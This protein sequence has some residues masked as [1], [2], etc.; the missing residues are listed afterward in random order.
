ME[1]MHLAEKEQFCE[2]IYVEYILPAVEQ[3][4]NYSKLKV[5]KL[6][7]PISCYTNFR[8][9]IFH[10][11]KMVVSYERQ[12]IEQQA[13]AIKEHLSRALTD[14]C[15]AILLWTAKVAEEFLD[16][17]KIQKKDRIKIREKVHKLKKLILIKR[18]NG[19]MLSF[20]EAIEASHGEINAELNE[21]FFFFDKNY[22]EQFKEKANKIRGSFC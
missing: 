15:N 7:L 8:D 3:L 11:R 14:A 20:D 1:R 9:A 12:E 2:Y 4:K 18:M 17:E 22:T 5:I 10:F 16:D 19:M 13:F 6:E 21:I